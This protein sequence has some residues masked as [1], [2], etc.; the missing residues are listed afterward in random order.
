[1]NAWIEAMR[2]RTLPVSVAGVVGGTACAIYHHGFSL[3]PFLICLLFAILAQISSN[4]ANEYYDFKNGLDKKGREGFRR[5]VTEGDISPRDM[6]MATYITLGIAVCI[7]ATLIIWGGWWLIFIGITIGIFALAYSTGPFPLSHNGLGEIAVIIFFG[8]IP[9]IFTE[10]VQ[11][12]VFLLDSNTIFSAAAIGLMGANV[13]IVNNYRDME[14]DREVGKRTSVVILGR[15]IMSGVYYANG[16][17][18]AIFL[19]MATSTLPFWVSAG[20]LTYFAFHT[21]LWGK[22]R[23]LSGAKLNDILKWTS[24]LMFFV[25]CYLLI[26]CASLPSDSSPVFFFP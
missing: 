14:D 13:L 21:M 8:F 18:A 10:Y 5:G 1:M 22:L 26:I 11:T 20:W 15:G 25:A 19:A 24:L 6:K 12:R 16:I 7:G 2:L 17:L 3:L 4:F 23:S 9:V